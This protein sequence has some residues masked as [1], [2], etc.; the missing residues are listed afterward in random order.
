MGAFVRWIESINHA[1]EA[2]AAAKLLNTML[3]EPAV[4]GV[5]PLYLVALAWLGHRWTTGR[6][7]R[8]WSRSHGFHL[9]AGPL[10]LLTAVAALAVGLLIAVARAAG[11][12]TFHSGARF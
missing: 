3:E 10:R 9:G 5:L 4:L 11:R 12:S 2:V 8:R 1:V 7:P 6:Q